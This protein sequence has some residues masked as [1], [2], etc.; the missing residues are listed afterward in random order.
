MAQEVGAEQVHVSNDFT[1][2]GRA[3]DRAV[4]EALPGNVE[5]VA[6]G[7]PY[8]VAPGT[9]MNG[10]G[11]PYQVFTPF[12]RAWRAVGWDAPLP[13]PRGV[14]WIEPRQR[15]ARRRD[16]G[17]RDRRRPGDDAHRR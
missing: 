9:V 11:R 4:V 13:A 8:A 10:S 17:E 3:R 7:T 12:S 14:D 5:G 1:P 2:Y 16:A 15:Q 6:T